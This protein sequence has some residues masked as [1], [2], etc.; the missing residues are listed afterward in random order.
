M[1]EE[2]GK[3]NLQPLLEEVLAPT[4]VMLSGYMAMGGGLGGGRFYIPDD[5]TVVFDQLFWN[6]PF[7]MYVYRDMEIK[8]AKV[9]GDLETRK[10]AVLALE[11]MVIPA[12]D[13]PQDKKVAEFIEETLEQYMGGSLVGGQLPFENVLREMMDA[14]GKGVVVGE[15]EWAIASDRRVFA[16]NVHFK[17]QSLFSFSEQAFG[18]SAGYASP[19]TGPLRLR[20]GLGY[21]LPGIDPDKSLEE[22]FP[23]KWIVHTPRPYQGNRW[24][25]PVDR[26]IF[27][28]SW[29]KRAGVKGWLRFTDKGP[30]TTVA[31]Y[32][33]GAAESE[34]QIAIDAARAV[35]EEQAVALANRFQIEVLEHAR[36]NM[37]STF[38][39]LV[40]E[41]SNS[42]IS[43]RI[44]GQTLTTR[45]GDRGSGSQALGNVHER[46]AESK[47]SADAKALMLTINISVVWPEVL[48]NFGPNVPPPMWTINYAPGA[49]LKLMSEVLYRGWQMG[50]PT[51]KKFYY[52]TMQTAP[53]IDEAD[54]LPPPSQQEQEGQVPGDQGED[55]AFAETTGDGRPATEK[56]KSSNTRLK[57][58]TSKRQRFAKLRPSMIESSND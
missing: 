55:A 45:G 52:E 14:I 22:Q 12:S 8:D 43:T 21:T 46:V 9:G 19:Q 36:G 38:K 41:F 26:E 13:S 49:D 50:V 1:A 54:T 44:L 57:P 2:N 10:E 25:E 32:P 6:Y 28:A 51:S 20:E 53:P 47:K 17:P 48:Y 5:P 7:A 31:R 11:R 27:W 37:G 42:E 34:K 16:K 39:E 15:I 56:K 23:N 30:G 18:T 40:D 29:I 24:G 3:K 4:D 33:D 58:P 35:A